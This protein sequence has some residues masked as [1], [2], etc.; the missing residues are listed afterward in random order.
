MCERERGIIIV[1]GCI[2]L[3]FDSPFRPVRLRILEISIRQPSSSSFVGLNV[4]INALPY[5]VFKSA[6]QSSFQQ[7]Q[8]FEEMLLLL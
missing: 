5:C 6:G 4:E 1:P 7:E 2:K 3:S 8:I